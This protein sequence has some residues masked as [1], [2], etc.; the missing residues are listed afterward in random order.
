[1]RL[2]YGAVTGPLRV[3]AATVLAV[4]LSACQLRVGV[5]IAVERDGAGELA[6]TV[7]ADDELLARARAA[8]AD[9]L[10]ALAEEGRRLA[11]DGWR[12]TTTARDVRLAADFSGPA[13]FEVLA[14][15]LAE[16][17]AAP[18]VRVLEPFTLELTGD[19]VTLR[20]AAGLRPTEAL[21]E[22]GVAPEEAV[23]LA[24]ADG[25]IDY[26]VRVRLP[27]EVLETTATRRERD[28]LVWDIAPGE[29]HEVLAVGTLPRWPPLVAAG[30]LLAL[31]GCGVAAV[32]LRRRR[33][34]ERRARAR[35]G[36]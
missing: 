14:A 25:M 32:A 36:G 4:L 16:A 15:D 1:M 18:E 5:D 29:R 8:G 23:R 7:G 19:R 27:G 21:A 11:A 17:L 3:L 30:G 12:V 2:A 13:E 28:L 34:R 35:S 20:G 10:A 22:L 31:V 26:E 6:V 9:P 24:A 33:S